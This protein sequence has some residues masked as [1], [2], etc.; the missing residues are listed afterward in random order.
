MVRRGEVKEMCVFVGAESAYLPCFLCSPFP[1]LA[2]VDIYHTYLS[3]FC[4]LFS[5]PSPSILVDLSQ[6]V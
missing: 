5:I 3:L 1:V 2:L 6:M 4:M